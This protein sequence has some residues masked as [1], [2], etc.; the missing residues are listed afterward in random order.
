MI[1]APRKPIVFVV[2]DDDILSEVDDAR[3]VFVVDDDK[4]W[5]VRFCLSGEGALLLL[6][7]VRVNATA[8]GED[9]DDVIFIRAALHDAYIFLKASNLEKKNK[10][11]VCVCVCVCVFFSLFFSL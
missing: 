6:L 1:P 3:V 10:T 8:E 4:V 5:I 2:W 7:K 11:R 9:E